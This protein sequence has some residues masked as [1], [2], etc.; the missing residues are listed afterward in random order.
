MSHAGLDLT[1]LIK[2]VPK[3]NERDVAKSFVLFLKVAN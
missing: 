1:K 2:I 3:F